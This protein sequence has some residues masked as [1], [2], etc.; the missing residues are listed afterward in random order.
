M[1]KSLSPLLAL[2]AA[3][4]PTPQ[5]NDLSR[6]PRSNYPP[7]IQLIHRGESYL[8]RTI[9]R[10]LSTVFEAEVE[11]R[12]GDALECQF[13]FSDG[14]WREWQTDCGVSRFFK[15]SGDY[16]LRA[17]VR[18]SYGAEATA[19]ALLQVVDNISPQLLVSPP[20][21]EF[22]D[23]GECIYRTKGEQPLCWD[24]SKS[25]D[26][27]GAIVGYFVDP[28]VNGGVMGTYSIP[29]FCGGYRFLGKFKGIICALDNEQAQD[30][31][32]FWGV[33]E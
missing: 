10:E 19:K 22:T 12:D 8:Q 25:Y 18:D 26:D 2:L 30:C 6:S 13:E 4:S 23:D 20:C 28:A 33:S 5:E 21:H 14:Y 1:F 15:R 29:T 16:F 31:L 24:C 17:S 7:T 11:D 27:D 3:C 9:R 32:E